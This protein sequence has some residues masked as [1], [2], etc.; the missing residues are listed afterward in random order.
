MNVSKLHLKNF[1]NY[2]DLSCQ[3]QRAGIHVLYGK[4]AQGKTNLIE[5]IYY[6]SHLRSFRTHNQ[7][8]MIHHDRNLFR[9]DA[10]IEQKKRK[11]ELRVVLT[12]KEKHLYRWNEPIRRYSDFIGMLNAVLFCPD[13]LIIFQQSPKM[14]R[15]FIDMELIKL[16]KMYTFTLNHYQKLL[17][18][19][20]AILKKATVDPI[21]FQT[22]TTQMIQDE[23]VILNQRIQFL[24]DLMKKTRKFYAFFTKDK[25]EIDAKY[26][27]F[28]PLKTDMKE[29]LIQ[30][31]KGH[32]ERD[33]ILKQTQVG[34]HKDDIDFHMNGISVK[35]I[36]SQ[37]QRRS[38]VLSMKLAL[39]Q[40]IYEK[41]KEYPVLLLDDV[42]SELDSL[43]S[44]QLI[45]IL[46]KEMQV[47]ITST[48]VMDLSWF[49]DRD[50]RFYEIC[51]GHLKEVRR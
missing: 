51:Q 50:V 13:D 49:K 33:K 18:Q 48:S 9:I 5:S 46:P 40:I 29:E 37:G 41:Q 44:R 23:V 20:N 39:C 22:L 35:D 34:I 4:N 26:Q 31:Y 8:H 47:F 10:H 3:F 17:R 2:E 12:P 6:L 15:R 30:A 21:L 36:A 32:E 45:S 24:E 7:V 42:F 28:I 43:R 16:S 38:F 1:R 14:R 25:E 11:E 19:R 27:T